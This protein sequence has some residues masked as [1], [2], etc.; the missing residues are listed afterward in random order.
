MSPEQAAGER[1]GPESDLY[2]LGVVLYEMLTGKAPFEVKTPADVPAEHAGG[3]PRHPRELNSE[4]PEALDA[5]VMRLW[6]EI[7]QNATEVQPRSSKNSGGSTVRSASTSS[8][9]DERP[10]AP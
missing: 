10:P 6:Q 2:S 7:R 1:V 4:V 5:I 8:S 9:G 3:P